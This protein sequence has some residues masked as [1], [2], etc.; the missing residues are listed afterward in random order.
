MSRV[1]SIF[2]PLIHEIYSRHNKILFLELE[3]WRKHFFATKKIFAI[4]S[5]EEDIS[6]ED[7]NIRS[8]DEFAISIVYCKL[9]RF[10]SCL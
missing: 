5:G 6:V 4:L 9:S 2:I 7:V 3:E 10:T 1:A 8:S